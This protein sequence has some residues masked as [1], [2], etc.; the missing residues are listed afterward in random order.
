MLTRLRFP[1]LT[2]L[3]I[4]VPD[5]DSAY[6]QDQPTPPTPPTVHEFGRGHGDRQGNGSEEQVRTRSPCSTASMIE[7]RHAM[8]TKSISFASVPGVVAVRIGRRREPD[9]PVRG[10]RRIDLQQSAARRHSAERAW[11]LLQLR[12]ADAGKHR[13]HR[14]AAWRA[15]GALRLG[16]DGERDQVFRCGRKAAVRKSTSP[17]MAARTILHFAGGVGAR[18]GA[19][20][21]PSPPLICIPTTANQTTP[22]SPRPCR[23]WWR[24]DALGWVRPLSGTR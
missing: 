23:G 16:R 12:D 15:L 19:S 22:T 14:G 20:S 9:R 18:S 2:I 7:Q 1:I 21:T 24:T 6:A 17:S 10:R 8:S 4:L 11:R 5:N 13:A 3:F